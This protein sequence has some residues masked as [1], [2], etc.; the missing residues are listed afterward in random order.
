[1]T[2]WLRDGEEYG[3][4]VIFE[5]TTLVAVWAEAVTVTYNPNGGTLMGG[6]LSFLQKKGEPLIYEPWLAKT[7]YV[8]DGWLLNGARYN[9][10]PLTQNVSLV[11]IWAQAITVTCDLTGGTYDG[12]STYVFEIKK[13]TSALDRLPPATRPGYPLAGWLL[14]D[15]LYA[16]QLLYQNTT[17]KAYWGETVTL[18]YKANGGTINGGST[19]NLELPK[20]QLAPILL[21]ERT[22]YYFDGWYIGPDYYQ[23]TPIIEDTILTA[24]WTLKPPPV[25]HLKAVATDMTIRLS[26]NQDDPQTEGY[27]IYRQAPGET[28]MTYRY[29]VTGK[30]FNDAVTQEG[31][32]FYRVYAYRTY[33]GVRYI[34]YSHS[35]VYATAQMPAPPAPVTNLKSQSSGMNITLSWT[36]S[37]GADGYMIYR[38]APGESSMAYRMLV[39]STSFRDA[40]TQEGFHYYRVFPYRTVNGIRNFGQSTRY[41][42][43]KSQVVAPPPISNLRAVTSGKTI[44]LSWKTSEP[45]DGYI[46]YRMGPGETTFKYR[47]MVTR[48]G[49]N[50][51]VSQAGT[52]FYRVYPYRVDTSGERLVGTSNRYV[53]GIVK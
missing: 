37:P 2:H 32:H 23:Q 10:Q 6:E 42:Y 30:A 50:D 36:A 53:Y 33:N 25:Y 18:T 14:N 21:P 9:N 38:Q 3:N 47:Y 35:Y 28:N 12:Q 41:V 1:M 40:V 39:T 49:F 17:L 16:G 5:D 46:V 52:Y 19:Y 43:A 45:V 22:N 13:G 7:G 15:T 4:Q 8:Q 34:S 51:T 24:A 48:L 11:A 26:W 44:A 20:G 31:F 29:M 27:I